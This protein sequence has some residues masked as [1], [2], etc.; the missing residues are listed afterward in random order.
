MFKLTISD[1]LNFYKT[2]NLQIDVIKM[3][4]FTCL[5]LLLELFEN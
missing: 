3:C 4:D 1:N 5:Q 2:I